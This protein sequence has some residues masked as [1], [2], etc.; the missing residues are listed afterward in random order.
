[1]ICNLRQY[2]NGIFC[3]SDACSRKGVNK[4]SR[5]A[6]LRACLGDGPVR[7]SEWSYGDRKLAESNVEGWDKCQ[8]RAGKSDYSP[9]RFGR[10][11]LQRA[12]LKLHK[13]Q[14]IRGHGI[15]TRDV[16]SKES[17]RRLKNSLSPEKSLHFS[18]HRETRS[19]F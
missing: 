10:A 7:D 9:R 15:A 1:M 6:H 14:D 5:K 12:D 13:E 16:K 3:S 11:N 17:R 4:R 2:K 8:A 19:V 18:K